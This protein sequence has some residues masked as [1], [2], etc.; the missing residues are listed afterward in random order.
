M[1]Q[2]HLA[3]ADALINRACYC[4]CMRS[5]FRVQL[6]TQDAFSTAAASAAAGL[7]SCN[8]PPSNATQQACCLLLLPCLLLLLLL[9][10]L[11]PGGVVHS[12]AGVPDAVIQ[13]EVQR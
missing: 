4:Q 6:G 13:A 12:H 1:P 9:R 8:L 5:T 11:L 3:V 10:L 7:L 2:Q